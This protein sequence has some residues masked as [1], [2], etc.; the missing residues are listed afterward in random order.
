MKEIRIEEIDREKMNKEKDNKLRNNSQQFYKELIGILKEKK[1]VKNDLHK[2]KIKLSKKY[3][4][5][6]IPTDIEVFLNT[7]YE[8]RNLLVTKPVRTISGVA[9]IALMTA[10]HKCPHGRCV[11][12]P[13]GPGSYYGDVPQSYTGKEPSTMRAIRNDYDPYLITMNRLEQYI[14]SGHIPEKAEIIIQGGTFPAMSKD[15]QDYFVKF[16]FKAMNDFSDLFYDKEKNE[17]HKKE[18]SNNA[19]SKFNFKKFKEFFELPGDIYDKVRVASVKEK[20]LKLKEKS[21]GKSASNI[22][23]KFT[24]E[25]E[26]LKNE[27]AMIRCVG[28]TIETK[29]DWGFLEH[30][31]EMLRQGATRIELGIQTTKDNVLKATN[32]GHTIKDSIKS[33]QILKDL[34]FKLNFHMMPGL[35]K[36]THEEDIEILKEIFDNPYYRPDMLKIYPCMVMPGTP[37]EIQYK[38]G[39]FIPITTQEAAEI[40]SEFKRYI[41]KYCRI[42]RIQRDIPTFQTTAGVDK[43]NLRQYVEELVNKKGITCQCIR[44]RE[45]GRKGIGKNYKIN[46]IEYNSSGG[47]EYFISA[48]SD[49]DSLLGFCRLRMPSESLRSEITSKTALIRELHV[50]GTAASLGIEGDVQHRGVG[51]KLMLKAEEIAKQN[52]KT[53]MCVISAVGT[54]EYYKKLG[55]KRDGVYMSKGL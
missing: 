52:S 10:P 2:L 17:N 23:N 3:N 5:G 45:A 12:C 42:Q 44:C 47:I 54:R 29:P 25:K 1:L 19:E 4:L 50:F 32:R 55:Y 9:V 30:G 7:E 35:P 46:V 15:Y 26:Q 22:S 31:N 16:I 20:L 28:L 41:P 21:S 33:I 38:R 40:I 39:Q 13:G 24:L 11:F 53:K 18:K 27:T 6:K 49:I 51:K 14:C 34:G 37:L 8:A 43:T 36:T 48:D